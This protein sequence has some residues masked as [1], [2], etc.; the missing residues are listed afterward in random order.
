MP[1]PLTLAASNGPDAPFAPQPASANTATSAT[2]T[3]ACQERLELVPRRREV[4]V[5]I[6]I[7][8]SCK[9]IRGCEQPAHAPDRLKPADR[10]ARPALAH[11]TV[12]RHFSAAYKTLSTSAPTGSAP[13]SLTLSE[14]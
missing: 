4:N 8:P 10:R 12:R 13:H 3:S 6:K 7:C 9:S 11:F 2:N 5:L 1:C 14:R